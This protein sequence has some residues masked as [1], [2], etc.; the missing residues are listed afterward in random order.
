MTQ[1]IRGGL[2]LCEALAMSLQK[3][4]IN[5]FLQSR[6]YYKLCAISAISI[7][8]FA[9]FAGLLWHAS[10]HDRFE[11]EWAVKST[12]V[13]SLLLPA[14]DSNIGAQEDAVR[15]IARSLDIDITLWTVDRE[16]ITSS[17]KPAILPDV[18][19]QQGVWFPQDGKSKWTTQLADGRYVTINVNN[20]GALSEVT[21]GWLT[22][23]LLGVFTAAAAYPF[24]LHVTRRIEALRSQVEQIGAGD[25][26]ARV[27][28]DGNDEVAELAENFNYA[29]EKI[30]RLVTAQRMLLANAS[31]ELR[32]PLARIRLGIEMLNPENEQQ[33]RYALTRDIE[34][35]DQL[36]DEIILMVRLD[37]GVQPDLFEQVDIMGIAAEECAR[38][39]NCLVSGSPAMMLGDR[40]M[41]QHLVRNLVD[42]AHA[43]GAPPINLK[44]DKDDTKIVLTVDDSGKGIPVSEREKV[45][46]PFY[47]ASDRQNVSGYGLGLPLIQ[48][49]AEL[50]NGRARINPEPFGS[51]SIIFETTQSQAIASRTPSNESNA[52]KGARIHRL[53]EVK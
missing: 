37:T 49:I 7:L 14:I 20:A 1:N 19:I 8:S 15:L 42:N 9:L 36:I 53:N 35:L 50:H 29:A 48:R 6:L 24:I 44:I 11:E 12:T 45:F 16:I 17:S 25:F 31:H 5:Q 13:A 46:Q 38:Y 34:E 28:V 23:L 2:S 51:I 3:R 27:K 10:G 22:L 40:R 4:K 21:L 43:H 32:T 30:E 47:R 41:L 18:A 39:D 26:G 52:K 33:T